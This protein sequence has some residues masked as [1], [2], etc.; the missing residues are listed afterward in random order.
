MHP[1]RKRYS[2]D[3]WLRSH[4]SAKALEAY[5]EQQGKS[6]SVVKNGFIVE[7][8]GDLSGKRFLDYGCGAGMF[9]V[10]A[11]KQGALEVVGVDAEDTAL[12]TA[13]F[14]ANSE[15]VGARCAFIQS[16]T[17]P[18]LSRTRGFDVILLKD[19]IEHVPDDQ[20]LIE[21]AARHLT[22]GGI[23]VL[24][25]QNSL[26]LN[27]LIE[28]TYQRKILGDKK[29]L[30]WDNTHLR[31]YTSLGLS[32]MLRKAGLEPQA[33]RS[34]YIIP[35]KIP[36]PGAAGKKFYRIEAFSWLDKALGAVFPY[37][38][39]GWN[40][41]VSAQDSGL[42]PSKSRIEPVIERVIPVTPV[43]VNRQSLRL[44]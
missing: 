41:I 13:R 19:V 5:L 44:K 2:D 10:H 22:P 42:A 29:W 31:F 24:S 35:H 28:G 15:G 21:T 37:N 9:S 14:F 17:F 36:K 26:S 34:V 18:R 1:E 11:A 8:L 16:S 12:A 30:G 7:L 33:W 38:R 43:S 27:Y 4:D 6:Y 23:I 20:G 40:I 3:H 32:R 39:L 25:T